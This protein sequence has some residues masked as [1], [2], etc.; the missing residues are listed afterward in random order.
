MLAFLY[1]FVNNFDLGLL[2]KKDV[3]SS[4][5]CWFECATVDFEMLINKWKGNGE[6]KR[7]KKGKQMVVIATFL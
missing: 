5:A 4:H 2:V 6:K 1:I 7:Q 3:L